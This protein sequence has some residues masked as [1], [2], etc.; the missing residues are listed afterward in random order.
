MQGMGSVRRRLWQVPLRTAGMGK[1]LIPNDEGNRQPRTKGRPVVDCIVTQ[2]GPNYVFAK[3]VQ[4]WRAILAQSQGAVVGANVAP[5]SHTESVRKNKLLAAGYDG[6]TRFG[7]EIFHPRTSS[8]LMTTLMLHDVYFPDRKP[9]SDHPFGLFMHGAVHGGM[10]RLP[11][12]LSS[13]VVPAAVIELAY[14]NKVQYVLAGAATA[15]IVAM[16]TRSKL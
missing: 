8:A 14:Q 5:A 9:S 1:I 2:Q 15:A 4:H 11:Y 12:K 10:W 6:S 3:R 13:V 16:R 7:V